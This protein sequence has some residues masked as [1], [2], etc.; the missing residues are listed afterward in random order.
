[1]LLN[2]FFKISAYNPYIMLYGWRYNTTIYYTKQ[3]PP[4]VDAIY[5]SNY[6]LL[7]FAILT[8]NASQIVVQYSTEGQTINLT[9]TRAPAYD[10]VVPEF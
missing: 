6:E 10:K 4:N 2:S 9:L 7:P 1:M 3:L 8:Q 5:N